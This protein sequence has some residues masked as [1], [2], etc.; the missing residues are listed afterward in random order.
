ML[1]SFFFFEDVGIDKIFLKKIIFNSSYSTIDLIRFVSPI[2][3]GFD[4]CP[5]PN[6]SNRTDW[7]NLVLKVILV[8]PS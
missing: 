5:V 8:I 2:K 7:P 6:Q 3:T 4:D 1:L